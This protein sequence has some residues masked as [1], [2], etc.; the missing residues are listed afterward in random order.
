MR[1]VIASSLNPSGVIFLNNII[2]PL[3]SIF[4]ILTERFPLLDNKSPQ[5]P[6]FIQPK[7]QKA[8]KIEESEY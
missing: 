4:H 6:P 5:S 8:H 7:Y 2:M 1:N 3:C